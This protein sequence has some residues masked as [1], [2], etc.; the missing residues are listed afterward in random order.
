MHSHYKE[1]EAEHAFLHHAYI[2]NGISLSTKGARGPLGPCLRDKLPP[3]GAAARHLLRRL[4][5]QGLE[6]GSVKWGRCEEGLV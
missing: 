2:L 4:R 3:T 5:H 1:A 6:G